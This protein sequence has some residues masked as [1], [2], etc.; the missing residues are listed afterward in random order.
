MP[1][2][3]RR[4]HQASPCLLHRR[5]LS[6]PI[7]RP[8]PTIPPRQLHQR[9]FA[10]ARRRLLRTR[11][12]SIL[13]RS[14]WHMII[15]GNP[16]LQAFRLSLRQESPAQG[17]RLLSSGHHPSTLEFIELRRCQRRLCPLP[18]CP[19][20]MGQVSQHRQVSLHHRHHSRQWQIKA[21]LDLLALPALH[22]AGT[23]TTH[24]PSQATRLGQ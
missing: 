20:L 1:R 16:L 18:G 24:I 22:Q 5:R 14:R 10:I 17:L 3:F 4:K 12:L 15:A 7:S 6:R 11:I 2:P 8:W 13:W 19:A 23:L 9:P 21:F